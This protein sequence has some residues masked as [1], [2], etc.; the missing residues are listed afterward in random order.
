[1][2]G[3]RAQE[4]LVER[5]GQFI[6]SLETPILVNGQVHR[7]SISVGVAKLESE[8]TSSDLIRMADIAMY[9]AKSSGKNGLVLFEDEMGTSVQVRASLENEL[10]EAW[11]NGEL[12]VAIQPIVNLKEQRVSGGEL[13]MRWTKSDGTVVPPSL[14]I[15]I[16]EENGMILEL[17]LW[18]IE[19][20]CIKLQSWA[21]DPNLSN[22]TIAVNVSGRQL[23]DEDFVAKIHYAIDCYSFDRSRLI[24]EVT[25][26]M[27][28]DESMGIDRKLKELKEMGLQ[29]ALDDF[30]TGYSSLS[31]LSRLPIDYLKI[32]QSFVMGM[33]SCSRTM[34]LTHSILL[35]AKGL[36]LKVI[37]EGIEELAHSQTLIKMGCDFGQGFVFSRP[38]PLDE[39]HLQIN[40]KSDIKVA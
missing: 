32:D 25:E 31:M 20:A 37:G 16:V 3:E 19:R 15:P 5:L 1:M 4:S 26:S 28:I 34:S 27:M 14:F 11:T 6:S 8:G 29:V 36:G 12:W 10:R 35:L 40:G 7:C 13:L 30:G 23:I 21:F 2:V 33:T 24:I 9:R 18:M 17:G 38:I 39:F 22:A